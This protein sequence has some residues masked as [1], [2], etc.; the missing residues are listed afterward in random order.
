VKSLE[1]E[2]WQREDPEKK[3]RSEGMLGQLQDAIAKLEAELAA[4]EA[5]GDERAIASARDALEARRA[6]L[7]AV[8]G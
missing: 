5:A 4:A 2:R 3:A 1:E 7:K 8:G 6:W